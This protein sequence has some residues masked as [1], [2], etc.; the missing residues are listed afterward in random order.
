MANG[1]EMYEEYKKKKNQT[2]TIKV[3]TPV[4]PLPVVTPEAV[5]KQSNNTP[6]VK[7]PGGS[8]PN[9]LD[10]AKQ[11]IAKQQPTRQMGIGFNVPT[12]IPENPFKNKVSQTLPYNPAALQ[13][14]QAIAQQAQ[15]KT[16]A[17]LRQQNIANINRVGDEMA[18]DTTKK[19]QDFFEK[20][21]QPKSVLG[22]NM[23]AG[24]GQFNK[25]LAQTADFILP[26]VITPKVVQQGIDSYNIH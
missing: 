8:L 1:F 24:L 4:V 23:W 15:G 7:V 21:V 20:P 3:P 25:S 12:P 22:A 18:Y 11:V 16:P 9:A 2:P 5:Y 13:K 6:S 10:A 17:Q 26:D 14:A 19:L